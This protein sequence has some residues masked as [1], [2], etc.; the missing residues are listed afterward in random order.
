[1]TCLFSVMKRFCDVQKLLQISL[2]LSTLSLAKE[3]GK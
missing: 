1:L 2:A 3:G